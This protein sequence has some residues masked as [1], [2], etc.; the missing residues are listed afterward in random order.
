MHNTS[1]SS[2]VQTPSPHPAT[3]EFLETDD[4]DDVENADVGKFPYG[5]TADE[6]EEER[7]AEE[8]DVTMGIVGI[9][10]DEYDEYDEDDVGNTGITGALWKTGFGGNDCC[11]G[12]GREPSMQ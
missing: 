6:L 9:E 2:L 10:D 5:N 3:T 8:E 4:E 12:A 11:S 7:A 1:P